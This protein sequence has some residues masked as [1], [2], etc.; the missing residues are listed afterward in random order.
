VLAG[1]AAPSTLAPQPPGCLE[2]V[3]TGSGKH[4]H[5]HLM[6]NGGEIPYDV[7]AAT[8][9]DPEAQKLIVRGENEQRAGYGFL[10]AAPALFL[11]AFISGWVGT[12]RPKHLE[13]WA[14]VTVPTLLGSEMLSL[15]IA[16][17]LAIVS[18]QSEKAAIERYN[19]DQGCR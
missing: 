7:K 11:G 9:G 3:R 8:A 2:V 18:G 15:G 5:S 16:V 6:K 17:T 4:S 12:D 13:P 19:Q 1:C 10:A 14:Q